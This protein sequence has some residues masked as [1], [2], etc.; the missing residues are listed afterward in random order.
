M[1]APMRTVTQRRINMRLFSQHSRKPGQSLVELA[2]VLPL[3][4]LI[5]ALSAQLGRAFTAYF[6]II[7]GAGVGAAYGMRSTETASDISGMTAAVLA[8]TPSI[9]GVEPQVSFPNCEVTETNRPNGEPYQCVAVRVDYDFRPI[10]AIWPIPSTVR[11]S[12]VV[13]MRVL[14]R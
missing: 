12:R 8:E 14:D 10:I 4:V 2:L 1:V 7:R 3:A 6:Q 5:L 11:M 13:E 9:W